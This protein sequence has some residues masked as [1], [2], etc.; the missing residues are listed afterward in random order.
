M[1]DI[2]DRVT[3]KQLVDMANAMADARRNLLDGLNHPTVDDAQREVM[4]AEANRIGGERGRIL[5]EIE[6]RMAAVA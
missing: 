2:M 3:T 6:R 1:S 5:D 4:H